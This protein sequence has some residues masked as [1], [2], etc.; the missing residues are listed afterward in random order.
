MTS[1]PTRLDLRQLAD[2]LDG[3]VVVAVVTG[4][5]GAGGVHHHAVVV[6]VG[7]LPEPVEA[8]GRAPCAG[9]GGDGDCEA[10]AGDDRERDQRDVPSSPVGTHPHAD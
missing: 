2:A 4:W 6:R 1:P 5:A 7:L 10:E 3:G 9:E 8:A